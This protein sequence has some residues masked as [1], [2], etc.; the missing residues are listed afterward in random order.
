MAGSNDYGNKLLLLELNGTAIANLMD[1]AASSPA[2]SLYLSL[3]TAS[4]VAGDQTTNEVSYTGYAR[5]A[6]ARNSG[7]ISISGLIGTLVANATFGLKT[8]G[9]NQTVTH[10]GFGRAASGTGLLMRFAAISSFST[11]D[12]RNPRLLAGATFNFV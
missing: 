8:A 3:H 7:G 10:V 6:V 11:A 4:P 9:S 2:T 1:N 5:A 12:G